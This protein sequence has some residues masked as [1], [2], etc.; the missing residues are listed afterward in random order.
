M[1]ESD[2]RPSPLLF[3]NTLTAYQRTAAIQAAIELDLFTALGEG[4]DTAAGLAERCRASERGVRIPADYL[5]ILGF[6]T[7]QEGRYVL[8]PDAALFLDRRSP[9]AAAWSH[10]SSCPTKIASRRPRARV[11]AS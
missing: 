6:L 10:W 1:Q 7:K 3:W 2:P 4:H 5:V 8:T 9:R 11:S